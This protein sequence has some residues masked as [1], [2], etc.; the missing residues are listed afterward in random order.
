MDN[1][2]TIDPK[3]AAKMLR[4]AGFD[5]N[6]DALREGLKVNAFPFGTA[7]RMTSNYKY[8]VYTKKLVDFI[9]DNGGRME[10]IDTGGVEVYGIRV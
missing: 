5:I 6:Y 1:R 9:L 8:I 7:Y 10:D 2:L 4:S 3:I